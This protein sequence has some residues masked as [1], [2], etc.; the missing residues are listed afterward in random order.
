MMMQPHGCEREREVVRAAKQLGLGPGQPDAA[1]EAHLRTCAACRELFDVARAMR[2][3]AA[4]TH[5]IAATRVLPEPAQLWWKARL[6]K[7]WDAETHATAPLDWM[8]RVEV[9]GGFIAVVVLLLMFWLDLRGMESTVVTGHLW[10]VVAGLL[11]PNALPTLIAGVL[12]L[13][14][15]VTLFMLRQL[16]VED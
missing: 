14:G 7:R 2:R 13:I 8:Q 11:A 3:L 9:F 16:L 6:L 1:I 12:L 10:P 4:D 15:C 5:A